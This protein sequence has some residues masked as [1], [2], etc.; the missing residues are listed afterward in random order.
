MATYAE[1]D[2]S[3]VWQNTIS[4][5]GVSAY[6]PPSGWTTRLV[7]TLPP[8]GAQGWTL[9]GSTWTSPVPT[10]PSVPTSITR[11]QFFIAAANLGVIPASAAIAL[12]SSGTMPAAFA[13]AI[14]SLPTAQQTPTT[15]MILGGANYQRNDP[16]IIALATALGYT[17]AQVDTFFIAAGNIAI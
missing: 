7:S 10:T 4:W 17:S 15:L 2:A 16:F 8:G 13:S 1:L 11:A 9:N 14:A 5:D 6:T 12:L 3:G